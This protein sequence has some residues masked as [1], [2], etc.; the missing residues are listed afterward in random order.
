MVACR[1]SQAAHALMPGFTLEPAARLHAIEIAVDVELQENRGVKGGPAGCCRLDTVEP[2]AGEIERIDE[3]VDG[4]NWIVFIN[5][6]SRHSGSSVDCPGLRLRF[7][8]TPQNYQG[9]HNHT[10][11]FTQPG[12]WSCNNALVGFP[13]GG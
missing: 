9:N 2:E 1:R 13:A 5:P 4:A 7:M 6:S 8:I 10:G 12:S 11:L 3:G